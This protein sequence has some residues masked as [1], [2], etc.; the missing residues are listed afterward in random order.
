MYKTL[1]GVKKLDKFFLSF[2]F[3]FFFFFIYLVREPEIIAG[4]L[5]HFVICSLEENLVIFV[6]LLHGAFI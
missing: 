1:Y 3:F 2:F 5:C 4:I 6:A